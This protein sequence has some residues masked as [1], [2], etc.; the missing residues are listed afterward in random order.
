MPRALF[1]AALL[2]LTPN[3]ALNFLSALHRHPFQ[4]ASKKAGRAPSTKSPSSLPHYPNSPSSANLLP[5]SPSD[6]N[7][8]DEDICWT[9]CQGAGNGNRETEGI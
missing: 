6:L 2:S 5:I 9:A 1:L 8:C 7:I 4:Y 3:V